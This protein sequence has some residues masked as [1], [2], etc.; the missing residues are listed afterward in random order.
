MFIASW[1]VSTLQGIRV[2]SLRRALAQ[3]QQ[4]PQ[5]CTDGSGRPRG[6]DGCPFPCVACG[7]SV[8]PSLSD[9]RASWKHAE[10]F[11]HPIVPRSAPRGARRCCPA[12]PT[13]HE[14]RFFYPIDWLQP[15]AVIRFGRAR[16]C[17]EG[18]GR[19]HRR[20]VYHLGDGRRWN[21]DA[22]RWRGG[23]GRRIRIASEADILGRV[24]RT[25]VVLAAAHRDND[26]ANNA[27]ANLAAFCQRGHMIHDRPTQ[28]DGK[29]EV[30]A[31]MFAFRAAVAAVRQP[32][33]NG[34]V[35]VRASSRRRPCSI[36]PFSSVAP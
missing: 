33:L 18:F 34:S 6:C 7:S 9:D 8:R 14:H 11:N 21:T 13:R 5:A 1:A 12:M 15:S 32:A 3:S 17:C 24:R 16:G 2:R 35:T 19:P 4:R 29:T 31:Q 22:A 10:A 25:R 23:R 36:S 27:D 28:A 30:Q 20:M 26:T